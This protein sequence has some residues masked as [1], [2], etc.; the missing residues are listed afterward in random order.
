ML[1]LKCQEMEK[2]LK[3]NEVM[4]LLTGLPGPAK[5]EKPADSGRDS[6]NEPIFK[7]YDAKNDAP[8]FRI[9]QTD[10]D[11]SN[12]GLILMNRFIEDGWLWWAGIVSTNSCRWVMSSMALWVNSVRTS[13]NGRTAPFVIGDLQSPWG[14]NWFHWSKKSFMSP[15]EFNR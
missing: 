3:L 8:S 14:F 7:S 4:A 15:V 10:Q 1:T 2:E 11:F 6:T 12:F 5:E 13:S 9:K